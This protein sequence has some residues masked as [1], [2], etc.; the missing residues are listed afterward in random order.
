MQYTNILKLLS[1]PSPALIAVIAPLVRD[2]NVRFY[3]LHNGRGYSDLPITDWFEPI[4]ILLTK[5][6]H[7]HDAQ[8]TNTISSSPR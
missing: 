2:G 7:Q 3:E 5:N 6:K 4:K 1:S 8:R